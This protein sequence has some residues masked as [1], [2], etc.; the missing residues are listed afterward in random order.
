MSY[1]F[2]SKTGNPNAYTEDNCNIFGF[3]GEPLGYI[4]ESLVYSYNGI[5]LGFYLDGWVRDING[6]CILFTKGAKGGPSKIRKDIGR[7][8]SPKL[9]IP[10]KLTRKKIQKN[11][12]IKQEWSE[13]SSREFFEK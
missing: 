5:H 2:Y 7:V 1:T 12:E 4:Y 6:F 10:I 8:K 9:K 3:N 11:L 13:L